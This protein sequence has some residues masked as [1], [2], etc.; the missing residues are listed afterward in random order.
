MAARPSSLAVEAFDPCFRL[1]GA[2]Q[3]CNVEREIIRACRAMARG[4]AQHWSVAW[5]ALAACVGVSAGAAETG[6]PG[7]GDDVDAVT[8]PLLASIEE[9]EALNGPFSRELVDLLTSL[10]LAYQEH[11]RHDLALVMFD[12]ALYLKR[13]NDGLFGLDQAG[14]V[15]RLVASEL[16]MGRV[17]SAAE[18]QDRLLE[19]ARRN[20]TD[21]RAAPILREAA[22]RQVDYYERYL[23]GAI[24]ATLTINGAGP[25]QA[26]GASLFRARQYYNEAIWALAL[27]GT[28]HQ[29]EISELEEGLTRTYYLEASQR[30]RSYQG[31]GDPLYGLGLVSYVRRVQYTR[32]G[33]PSAVDYARA[34]IEL[35][36]WSLLFSR[37]GT[38]VKRYAEA[39]ALLVAN[40][41]PAASIE[42]LFP[43]ATPVSL[44]T[45]APTPFAEAAGAGSTG[46]V[47]VD[48]EVGKYGQP[49]DVT[50]VAVAG[51]AGAATSRELAT[52]IH[53]SRFRP[54]PLAEE[55]WTGYRLRYSLADG[56]LTPRL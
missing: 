42:Q 15:R 23:H 38:A 16:A 53:R 34:L 40:G 20:P 49:R 44:P 1:N 37:N 2:A 24:P 52:A 29:G 14:L 35:A 43:A 46:Y 7:S 18:L 17:S 33:S 19:L 13:V 31:P 9:E 41:V 32:A 27:D 11:D 45:F 8:E 3:S 39:H 25:Q 6:A 28:E 47:D 55:N 56:R 4:P 12:R 30:R 51:D 22:E 48:F 50:I 21:P 36:D 10:G 5:L 54:S 26:A